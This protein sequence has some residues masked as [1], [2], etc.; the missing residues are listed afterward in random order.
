MTAP[1]EETDLVAYVDGQ[2]DLARRIEVEAWLAANPAAAA[3]VMTDLSLR[4]TL[5]FEFAQV[6]TSPSAPAFDGAR[7]LGRG[8]RWRSVMLRVR[9]AAAIL[10]LLGAG[11]A[12]HAWLG[13][14]GAGPVA[15]APALPLYAD[16]AIDA[17]RTTMLRD[18]AGL[19]ALPADEARA[20]A[21]LVGIAL[22][23]LPAGWS[24]G[25]IEVVPWD[26]GSGIEAVL[27]SA[28]LGA[29]TLFAAATP[30]F[31]VTAP[32]AVRSGGLAVAYWRV[33]HQVYALC[34][35][36]PAASVLAAAEGLAA[37][38]W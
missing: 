5:Q 26:D 22:P 8:L 14:T 7:R 29:A 16:E 12:S 34:A 2:L 25:A 32:A 20:A 17:H 13:V 35:D 24:L 33:G 38:L 3:R 21:A 11:W 31:A 6:G 19:P 18:A 1:V 4:D 36:A 28:D 23:A 9:R 30:E 15:A 27:T 37:T 10:L